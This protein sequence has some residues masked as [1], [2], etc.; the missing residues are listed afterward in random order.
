MWRRA[1]STSRRM[2]CGGG[3]SSSRPRCPTTTATGK[4][5]DSGD[6]AGHLARAQELGDWAGFGRRRAAAHAR[7]RLRGIGI[8]TYIEACGNDGPETAIVR[9]DPDGGI[10]V[11]IGTQSTGQGHHTAYA[12]LIAERL[13]LAPDHV[14]VIQGD[15]DLVATGTGTGGSNSIPCGGASVAG[16]ADQLAD[17]LAGARRQC[18]GSSRRRSRIRHRILW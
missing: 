1:S 15:T 17:R 18:A 2:R 11:L 16:A 10:T 5:Y 8:A 3:T 6:F 4:T 13:R 7:G 14:R 9:L 12:Q